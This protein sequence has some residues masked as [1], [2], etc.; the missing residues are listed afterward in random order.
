M[1]ARRSLVWFVAHAEFFIYSKFSLHKPNHA[2]AFVQ[3]KFTGN[4]G[5]SNASQICPPLDALR[6]LN[7]AFPVSVAK[8]CP[9]PRV[10]LR[11]LSWR[12]KCVVSQLRG[13]ILVL[14]FQTSS[15]ECCRKAVVKKRARS[16]DFQAYEGGGLAEKTRGFE[17]WEIRRRR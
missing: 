4:A 9:K 6:A 7:G 17:E 3:G 13:Q 1:A 2:G 11:C 10:E 5:S 16:E 15:S 8:E 14:H 12:K